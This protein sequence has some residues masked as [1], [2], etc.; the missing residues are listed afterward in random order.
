MLLRVVTAYGE[1]M[2]LGC[3]GRCERAYGR[4]D[5]PKVFAGTGN[6]DDWA[7]LADSEIKELAPENPGS[8]EGGVGKPKE[9]ADRLNRWCFR[10]CERSVF[11]GSRETLVELPNLSKRYYNIAPHTRHETTCMEDDC[12]AEVVLG[13]ITGFTPRNNLVQWGAMH[14]RPRLPARTGVNK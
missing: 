2:A 4:Q 14:P 13:G 5:R 11:A 7:W 8:Y 1:R 3:D 10:E 12:G 9:A 6:D